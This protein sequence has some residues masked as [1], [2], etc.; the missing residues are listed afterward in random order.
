[1]TSRAEQIRAQVAK[2][3]ARA[4]AEVPASSA[5]VPHRPRANPVRRTVDLPPHQHAQLSTWCAETAQELGR[6]RVTGQEVLRALVARLLTDETL[7]RKI[8]QDL[9]G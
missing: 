7:A 1:M 6:S 9:A 8:R 2:S 3:R 5:E 4:E